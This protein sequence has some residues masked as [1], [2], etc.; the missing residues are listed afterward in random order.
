MSL[1]SN[2][3]AYFD[4]LKGLLILLVLVGHFFQDYPSIRWPIYTFHMPLFVFLSGYFSKSSFSEGRYRAEKPAGLLL[5]YL[6]ASILSCWVQG[7]WLPTFLRPQWGLWYLQA[8]FVW[9]VCAPLVTVLRNHFACMLA[10]FLFVAWVSEATALG[11]TPWMSIL[12]YAPFFI[13]GHLA[14]KDF[15]DAFHVKKLANWILNR[16]IAWGGGGVAITLSAILLWHFDKVSEIFWHY[17]MPMGFSSPTGFAGWALRL[18]VIAPLFSTALLTLM[19]R[20]RLPLAFLG[21]RTLPIYVFHAVFWPWEW[22]SR[23]WLATI[24]DGKTASLLALLLWL[25]CFLMPFWHILLNK[26][27]SLPIYIIGNGKTLQQSS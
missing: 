16:P 10:L 23:E 14:P 21:E 5:L 24:A 17:D 18:F 7:H 15:H 27:Q 9:Y 8:L 6:G 20:R 19:P 4:N 25:G 12:Q 13:L 22:Q 26:L 3:I 1:Q 11:A 2:R